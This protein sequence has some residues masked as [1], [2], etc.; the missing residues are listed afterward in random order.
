MELKKHTHLKKIMIILLIKFNNWMVVIRPIASKLGEKYM[1]QNL[2]KI[3]YYIVFF[4]KN[5]KS[6][7][8]GDIKDIH[9]TKKL[10]YD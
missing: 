5:K 4:P 3:K 8:L 7:N 1:M 10:N 6:N 2:G 9:L